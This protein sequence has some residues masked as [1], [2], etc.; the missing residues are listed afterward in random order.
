[1]ASSFIDTVKGILVNPVPTFQSLKEVTLGEALKYFLILVVIYSLLSAIIASVG[2]G[3][4]LF[5]FMTGSD[6]V[7][8]GAMAFVT[9]LVTSI[10]LMIILTFIIAAIVHI[11]VILL[12]GT[13]G[14]HQTMKGIIYGGTPSY[15]LG[16]IPVIG[17][18]F[19]LWGFILEILGIRELQQIS[20]VRAI[21]AVIIPIIIIFIIIIVVVALV[22][23]A[24][25]FA[26]A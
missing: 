21:L 13:Q 3:S 24:F 15:L 14:F 1:M 12:G 9:V 22:M 8:G 11:F 16:W 7:A 17:I 26:M 23:S 10:I 20:T 25:I 6:A 5:P 19:H 4:G 2:V 18:I